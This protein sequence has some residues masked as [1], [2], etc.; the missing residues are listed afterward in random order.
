MAPSPTSPPPAAPR[1][2]ALRPGRG[3]VAPLGRAA[4]LAPA[5]LLAALGASPALAQQPPAAVE[6][7]RPAPAVPVRPDTPA[8]PASPG[9]SPG[10]PPSAAGTPTP[11]A[12]PAGPSPASGAGAPAPP[13]PGST[14]VFT[15]TSPAADE[16]LPSGEI[17]SR[18]TAN[19]DAWRVR[20]PHV[21][22]SREADGTWGGTLV[23]EDVRLE[24]TPTRISG[25]G[26][27]L[28][29]TRERDMLTVE[30]VFRGTRVRLEV[31]ST[32][33]QGRIGALAVDNVRRADGHWYRDDI[34][35]EVPS[36]RFTGT[37][38]AMPDVP[39]PQWILAFI[40]SL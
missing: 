3:A 37:A 36:I 25:A 4:R 39:M 40:G 31:T 26:V 9:S 22:M 14:R 13:A 27:N 8:A 33:M 10:A 38:D 29:V 21:N 1:G 19:Y 5:L 28:V 18:S 16:Y 24:V 12:A 23:R 2:P 30:G 20:G 17:L 32:A 34:P 35:T 7:G 15:A 6:A 11:P